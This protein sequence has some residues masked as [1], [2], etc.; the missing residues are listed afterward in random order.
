MFNTN[1]GVLSVPTAAALVAANPS[2]GGGGMTNGQTNVNLT[3]SFAGN[4]SNLS[5]FWNAGLAIQ[6]VVQSAAS[7]NS[8]ASLYSV[9]ATANLDGGLAGCATNGLSLNGARQAVF[10]DPIT[11]GQLIL[12]GLTNGGASL[13]RMSVTNATNNG[14]VAVLTQNVFTPVWTGPGSGN[15]VTGTYVDVTGNI[16]LLNVGGATYQANGTAIVAA[17]NVLTTV[18]PYSL[19]SNGII[20][21]Q[22]AWWTN[23]AGATLPGLGAANCMAYNP[24]SRQIFIGCQYSFQTANGTNTT[25]ATAYYT[26][27]PLQYSIMVY[28]TTPIATNGGWPV[29][30]F[31]GWLEANVPLPQS[32]VVNGCHALAYK[33]Y[34][35]NYLVQVG[36][37]NSGLNLNCD[38]YFCCLLNG[39]K[40]VMR[41][42]PMGRVF[43]SGAFFTNIDEL[44]FVGVTDAGNN[45]FWYFSL[46]GTNIVEAQI[47]GKISLC[48]SPGGNI[49]LGQPS[50]AVGNVA[51]GRLA[52]ANNAEANPYGIENTAIGNSALDINTSGSQNVA[53][54]YEAGLRNASGSGNVSVGVLANGAEANNNDNVAV[55]NGALAANVWYGNTAIGHEALYG[56]SGAY[57]IGVG[58]Q[59]GYNLATSGT[60]DYNIDVSG[61]S[62]PATKGRMKTS[63]FEG[64]IAFWA[65]RA[66]HGRNERTQREL[67][68]FDINFGGQR[69]VQPADCA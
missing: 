9:L 39:S 46:A 11:N 69:L 18:N 4:G 56:A 3:G 53:V 63:H 38:V 1:T 25:N 6:S 36:G 8:N 40:N 29:W 52:L 41:S 22:A 20:W 55:G 54:G 21:L 28:G 68:A 30:P 57:N 31:Q 66:A 27:M 17:S 62:K 64:S 42:D 50:D 51:L 34:P 67:A 61:H 5:G 24:H 58:Y 23:S 35:Y 12:L 13:Q 32:P 59:A 26:A 15:V 44:G 2:L 48:G 49:C 37:E 16:C 33:D 10:P 60:A 65:A 47:N 14:G 19:L 45:A 7:V 43:Q